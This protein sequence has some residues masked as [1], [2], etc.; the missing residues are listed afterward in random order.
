MRVRPNKSGRKRGKIFEAIRS[1]AIRQ[2]TF[3]E[4]DLV[5]GMTPYQAKVNLKH[6]SEVGELRRLRREIVQRDGFCDVQWIYEKTKRL[7]P[8]EL[9]NRQ[10]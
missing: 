9:T 7:R 1:L 4:D 6:L 2:K 3:K 10:L 8:A 5:P